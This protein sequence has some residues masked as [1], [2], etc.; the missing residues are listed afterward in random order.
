MVATRLAWPNFAWRFGTTPEEL[1]RHLAMMAPDDRPKSWTGGKIRRR[2]LFLRAERNTMEQLL[3]APWL[4]DALDDA[5]T[6]RAEC[7]AKVLPLLQAAFPKARIAGAGTLT[8]ADLVEDRTQIAASLGDI[9]QAY[10]GKAAGG[11][12][13]VDRNQAASLRRRARGRPDRMIA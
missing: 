10:G 7:E 12:L 11:W 6:V 8:P 2:R 3:F 13:P 1:P 5:R 9:A 4:A